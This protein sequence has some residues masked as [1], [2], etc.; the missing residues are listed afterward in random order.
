MPGE[1]PKFQFHILRGRRSLYV[2][3]DGWM[4][5]C[6]VQ[7]DVEGRTH[8]ARICVPAWNA[9][10]TAKFKFTKPPLILIFFK[11]EKKRENAKKMEK[12]KRKSAKSKKHKS[13]IKGKKRKDKKGKKWEK[14]TCPFAF[15]LFC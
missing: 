9:V 1:A 15:F 14:M 10:V 8:G 6:M 13:K 11:L 3:M 4:D 2:W 12:P 7:V 5:G